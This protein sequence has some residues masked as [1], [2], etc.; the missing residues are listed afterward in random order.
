MASLIREYR[1]RLTED[2][3][4]YSV[5]AWGDVAGHV[6]YGWLEFAPGRFGLPVRTE[7]ET[8]QPNWG[9]LTYWARGLEPTYLEGAFRRARLVVSAEGGVQASFTPAEGRRLLALRESYQRGRF[10]D[11][12]PPAF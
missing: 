2:G 3:V 8:T 9:A 6:W 10:A 5:Q 12:H 4:S 7:R 1:E 11:D